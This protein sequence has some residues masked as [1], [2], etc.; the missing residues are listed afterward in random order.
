M[1]AFPEK[2]SPGEVFLFR[3]TETDPPRHE[4]RRGFG[5]F[6]I[7]AIPEDVT[8]SHTLTFETKEEALLYWESL[9]I[10]PREIP[11]EPVLMELYKTGTIQRWFPE[12]ECVT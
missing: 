2:V 6:M 8:R 5:T 9:G 12:G 11:F 4:S 10:V 3:W 7:L 1:S